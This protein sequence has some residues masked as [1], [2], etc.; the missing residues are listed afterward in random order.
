M[1]D[2]MQIVQQWL[3]EIGGF[4]DA[5]LQL[6]SEGICSF[7]IDNKTAVTIEVS[8]DF[9]VVNLYS[10]LLVLPA[11][12]RE[13]SIMLMEQALELNAFQAITRGGAIGAPPGGGLL[14]FSYSLP[15]QETDTERFSQVL[16]S[17]L[18]TIE[19]LKNMLTQSLAPA[20]NG[21]TLP[22]VGT[23]KIINMIKI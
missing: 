17:F 9:P 16:Q 2:E 10:N 7:L 18:E 13:K 1:N 12:D 5:D 3:K 11:D 4:L 6:D 21:G 22:R 19:E 15:I 14:I 23:R 20:A 8:P